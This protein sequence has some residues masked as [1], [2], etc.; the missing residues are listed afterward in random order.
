M[1]LY[2]TAAIIIILVAACFFIYIKRCRV[3]PECGGRNTFIFVKTELADVRKIKLSE[4]RKIKTVSTL[5]SAGK[6]RVR[7]KRMRTEFFAC[8]VHCNAFYRC[9]NCG[10]VGFE[11]T[12]ETVKKS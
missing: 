5:N 4:K 8:E 3:C 9:K 7:Y 11:R 10:Y 6:A 1:R 2:L 12:I